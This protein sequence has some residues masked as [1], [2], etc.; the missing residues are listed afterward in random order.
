MVGRAPR[1]AFMLPDGDHLVEVNGVTQ[2]VG[3]RGSDRATVPLLVIH[4]GPGANNW[5]YEQT[6]GTALAAHRTVVLHEQRGC[7]RATPPPDPDAYSLETLVSDIHGVVDLL[8]VPQVDLLGWSF[9]AD[10]ASRVALERPDRVRR[11]V[12]QAPALDFT[13]DVVPNYLLRNF[14]EAATPRVR[15]DIAHVVASDGDPWERMSRLWPV[16]DAETAARVGYSSP[17][18]AARADG[19]YEELRIGTNMDMLAAL[20]R[21]PAPTAHTAVDPV[22]PRLGEIRQPTLVMAGA[23]DRNVDPDRARGFADA[24]RDVRLAWFPN[25]AH[26]LELEEPDAYVAELLAFLD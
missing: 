17:E 23:R 19:L 5:I 6:V 26:M 22:V 24:I 18:H 12:L 10:L 7:G 15:D 20:T 1:L 11:L 25:A 3:V 14:L 2:W 9:G 13:D 4:G 8:D 16:V 21:A